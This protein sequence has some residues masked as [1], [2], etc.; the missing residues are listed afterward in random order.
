MAARSIWKGSISLGL[1]NIPIKLYPATEG[2][3]FSFHQMCSKSHRIEYKR[4][5]PAE[6]REVPWSEIQKGYEISK[7]R[8]IVLQ[9]EDFE[10]IK[11]KT[12]KIIVIFCG[13]W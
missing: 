6:E 12:T 7:E 8:Y 3:E 9:K 4:W 1:V 13:F 11:I 5:C 2:K 10:S